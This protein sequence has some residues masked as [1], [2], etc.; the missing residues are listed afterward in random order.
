[1]AAITTIMSIENDELH[2][3]DDEEVSFACCDRDPNTIHFGGRDE[4]ILPTAFVTTILCAA[5][6]DDPLKCA[7]TAQ[8]S[9]LGPACV[10][11]RD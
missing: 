8:V 1:M 11:T 6:C 2:D 5:K 3:R 9:A 10:K 7:S 4:I